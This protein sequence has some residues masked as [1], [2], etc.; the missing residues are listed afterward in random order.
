MK[1]NNQ[2]PTTAP[3]AV[4]VTPQELLTPFFATTNSYD[5][6]QMNPFALMRQFTE[7][8]N[9]LTETFGGWPRLQ[10]AGE[11][12][13]KPAIETYEKDGKFIVRTELP[14]MSDK[15]I[16]LQVVDNRL[17]IK[18]ERKQETAK[19]DKNYHFSELTYGSCYRA[20]PL[21][22]EAEVSQITAEFHNGVLEV[23]TPLKKK[24]AP[25]TPI[26]V[27]VKNKDTKTAT[28]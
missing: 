12:T 19:E 11:T 1:A 13:W 20:I 14:G 5:L 9:R 28:A 10:T 2:T 25:Q 8:M 6:F 16:R 7:E 24:E 23:I 17:L 4:P 3:P 21:P 15:D 26:P 22:G 18:G 27:S